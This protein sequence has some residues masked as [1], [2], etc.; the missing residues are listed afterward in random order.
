MIYWYFRGSYARWFEVIL[1]RV[2]VLHAV[3]LIMEKEFS[4]KTFSIEANLPK[5]DDPYYNRFIVS[6]QE[7]SPEDLSLLEEEPVI[8]EVRLKNPW[9]LDRYEYICVDYVLCFE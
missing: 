3:K 5:K 7:T 1:D 8:R 9:T 4:F 2:I 6:N